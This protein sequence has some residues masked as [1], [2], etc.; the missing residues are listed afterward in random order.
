MQVFPPE[1]TKV[2]QGRSRKREWAPQKEMEI[3]RH[4]LTKLTTF[5]PQGLVCPCREPV[6]TPE[7]IA[8][9]EMLIFQ[10]LTLK[11]SSPLPAYRPGFLSVGPTGIGRAI[12]VCCGGCPVYGTCLAASLSSIKMCFAEKNESNCISNE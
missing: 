1:T 5:R 12:S 7:V 3:H 6:T 9:K 4:F 2:S 8:L 10:Y 11:S